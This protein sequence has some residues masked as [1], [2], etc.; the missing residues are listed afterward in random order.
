MLRTKEESEMLY[1]ELKAVF[2]EESQ[3]STLWKILDGNPAERNLMQLSDKFLG[4]Y[5]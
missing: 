2:P 4:E 5:F 3:D 1:R